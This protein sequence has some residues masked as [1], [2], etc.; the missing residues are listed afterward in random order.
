MRKI[1]HMIQ[2]I[3]AIIWGEQ[4]DKVYLFVHGKFSR[5]EDAEG[6]ALKAC[7]KGYQ[8]ISFDLPEHGERKGQDLE[9]NPWNG[10]SDLTLIGEYVRKQWRELYLVAFSLGAYFSL[11]AYKDIPFK[12]CLF[13]APV[14]N[15]EN[16]IQNMMRWSKVEEIE[17]MEKKE[18]PTS[19][20][21]ILSW[22]YYSFVKNHP[23][24]AWDIQTKILYGSKDHL[25]EPMVMDEFVTKFNCELTIIEG[26]EHQINTPEQASIM[27]QWLESN[28]I[29]IN[30]VIL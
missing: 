12:E 19:M 24:I 2:G 9:C 16:L 4:S 14:V 25:T 8:V 29:P 27:E 5:K 3:P 1:R 15:M 13:I 28:I 7:A 21:E 11:L 23:I 17:L 26:L 10:I 30:G 22:E 20:G 6:F 18:I